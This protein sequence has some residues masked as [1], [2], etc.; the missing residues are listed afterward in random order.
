M[1]DIWRDADHLL[2]IDVFMSQGPFAWVMWLV[3]EPYVTVVYTVNDEEITYGNLQ[4]VV[5]PTK[6]TVET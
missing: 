2:F 4:Y 1:L 6:N 5:N 3:L